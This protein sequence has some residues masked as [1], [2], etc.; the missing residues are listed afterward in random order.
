MLRQAQH[1]R[2]IS[3]NFGLC[4]VGPELCRRVNGGFFSTLLVIWNMH[5]S[6]GHRERYGLDEKA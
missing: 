6:I 4:A 5:C 1:E 3:N 2:K